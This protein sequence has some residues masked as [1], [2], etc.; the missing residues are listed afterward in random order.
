MDTNAL[1]AQAAFRADH[2]AAIHCLACV[3]FRTHVLFSM[4][5]PFLKR[6]FCCWFF[7]AGV[8]IAAPTPIW[9]L[10]SPNAD[11][12]LMT[13]GENEKASLVKDGWTVEAAGEVKEEQVPN[14]ALLHRMIRSGPK[15]LDRML[16]SDGAKW[17]DWKKAGF[18][19]EGQLGFVSAVKVKDGI[20]VIQ[21]TH[22]DKRLWVT[23]PA[24]AK[25]LEAKGWKRQG[26]QFWIWP[27]S[28][29]KAAD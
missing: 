20:P 28:K 2:P 4:A 24:S 18:V 26:T 7:V 10:L 19:E 17:E 12:S 11:D 13:L 22:D 9:L 21:F 5:I 27:V 6:L 15:G 23:Q 8:A 1:E 14:S 29:P 25:A 16:E 3:R